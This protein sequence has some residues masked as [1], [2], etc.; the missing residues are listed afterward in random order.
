MLH[1]NQER[2]EKR[3]ERR[4]AALAPPSD[5]KKKG[6]SLLRSI[7]GGENEQWNDRHRVLFSEPGVQC[8]AGGPGEEGEA[9]AGAG[10]MAPPSILHFVVLLLENHA[11]D[12][13]FGCMGLE[14]FDGIRAGHTLPVDPDDPSKGVVHVSCG[15]APYVCTN[16]PGYDTFAS[17]F[18]LNG[19]NPHSY[20]Y[21]EQ[22]DRYSAPRGARSGSTSVQM[23]AP[24]Q[25]PVKAA[26]A[27]EFGVFNRLYTAVPSASSP[28]HL[29]AQSATSCGMTANVLYDD[30]GGSTVTFPQKTIFDSLKSHGVSFGFYLNSTCGTDENPCHGEDPHN[31]DSASA[32]NT[33][34]VAMEGVGRHK[35]RFF[36]QE[37]FY[38]QAASGTLPRLVWL[39]PPIQ[40]CDHPCHDIAKGERFLK[41]IY[42]ALRAGPNWHRT[43]FFVS[44]ARL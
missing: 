43:V 28:N 12:N 21:S 34:D 2:R 41:D 7:W 10:G 19:S 13:L 24:E 27:K 22:D 1:S 18:P 31:P 5:E 25:I 9:A 8:T 38:H 11:A 32:I 33:P 23:F 26:L 29:F 20:P 4:R 44:G 40:A 37:L 30:C 39:H 6:G 36:S 15:S 14:G 35:D 42:E 17:K 16:A 3:E